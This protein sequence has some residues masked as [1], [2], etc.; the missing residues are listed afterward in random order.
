M[1]GR[2]KMSDKKELQ[3][4]YKQYKPDMGIIAFRNLATGKVYLAISKNTKADINSISFQLTLG[5]YPSNAN[6]CEDWK[7]Q[8]QADF[9]IA[10]LEKLEYSKDE[11]KTDYTAD[12]KLLREICTES[13]KNYE[14]IQ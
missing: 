10:V 9:E 12:L 11:S 3:E 4:K 13:L 7:T 2:K 14:F 8:G 1:L 6:L 5:S